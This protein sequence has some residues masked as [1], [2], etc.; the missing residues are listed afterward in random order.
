[1]LDFTYPHRRF[2]PLTGDWILV[3]PQRTL[4]PW[5]GSVESQSGDTVPDYD[6]D[7]YLC[8]G[9]TRA[10]GVVNPKYDRTFVFTNDH[11][12]LIPDP[13]PGSHASGDLLLAQQERGTSRVVCYTPHH[14]RT[15]AQMNEQEIVEVIKTWTQE[16]ETIGKSEYISYVQIFENKGAIM[17]PSSPHPHS[18]IWANEHLPTIIEREQINQ[19][20]FLK[21]HKEPL[22][23]SYLR[24][25]VK[26]QK[27]IILENTSFVCL[28]PFWATWPYET[29]I[30]PKTDKQSLSDLR[31]GDQRDLADILLHITRRYDNLFHAPFPYSMGIHQKPT[32]GAAHAEWQFHIHFYPPLLRSATVKK[33]YVGYEMFAEGQRDISPEAAAQTLRELHE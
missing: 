17:G 6:Q 24:E 26:E 30:L 10:S 33:H 23:T 21:K 12:S 7:C 13:Q 32:D 5:Q 15:M 28:V 20:I 16:Y 2:N 27:R 18:Q 29:M 1:M 22:L 3:S 14:N 4:R 8:P 9:N 25:E 19:K 11:P 31:P